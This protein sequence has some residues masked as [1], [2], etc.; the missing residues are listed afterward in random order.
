MG[1]HIDIVAGAW[2][3]GTITEEGGGPAQWIVVVENRKRWLTVEVEP[4]M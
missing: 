2:E 1:N 4:L 3:D